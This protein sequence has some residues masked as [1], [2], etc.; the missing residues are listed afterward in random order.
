MFLL[1][2]CFELQI[3]LIPQCCFLTAPGLSLPL[4]PSS[5]MAITRN[6]SLCHSQKLPP[7]HHIGCSGLS[8]LLFGQTSG[9]PCFTPPCDGTLWDLAISVFSAFADFPMMLLTQSSVSEHHPSF[10][11]V[12]R[13]FPHV[14]SHEP[15]ID[16]CVYSYLSVRNQDQQYPSLLYCCSVFRLDVVVYEV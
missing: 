15:F 2:P 10:S 14:V 16:L 7:C 12:R 11:P 3:S 8:C 9:S 6:L 5:G 4:I 1:P 13:F